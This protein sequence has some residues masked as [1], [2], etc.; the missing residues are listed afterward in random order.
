MLNSYPILLIPPQV[1]RILTA[2]PLLPN[3]PIEP[4]KPELIKPK[5]PDVPEKPS[6][7][8]GLGCGLLLIFIFVLSL[9]GITSSDFLGDIFAN[10]IFIFL[11]IFSIP[12][13]AIFVLYTTFSGRNDE[14]NKYYERLNKFEG[15]YKKHLN[16]ITN[17]ETEYKANLNYYITI[18][19]PE[20]LHSL[21]LYEFEKKELIKKEN[22]I[23][24]R[25]K[26]LTSYFKVPRHERCKNRYHVG[27]SEEIFYWFLKNQ[28]ENFIRGIT[29]TGGSLLERHYL[30]DIVYYDE[31][32]GI[33]IDIEIDEPY[34]G[35]DGTPI[36]YIGSDDDRNKRF[37][38]NGWIVI[39]FCEEQVV[40]YP[41]E[42][43][44]FINNCIDTLKRASLDFKSINIHRIPQWSKEEAHKMAFMRKRNVYL[45]KPLIEKMISEV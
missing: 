4:V 22:I 2:L 13:L 27:V 20:Y 39:R 40:K 9:I 17:Y 3:P 38:D 42:C 24:Y 5:E 30:P 45:S 35:S 15:E 12:I 14:L 8:E 33:L 11:I 7:K 44:L 18:A 34:L 10:N 37:L 16:D 23:K 21:E 19:Y 31:S 28:S 36:H 29:I 1:E 32:F 41:N 6:I 43:Y 26:K 25:L